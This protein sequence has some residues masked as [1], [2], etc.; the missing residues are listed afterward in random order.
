MESGLE[1]RELLTGAVATA[2]LTGWRVLPGVRSERPLALI[3]RGPASSPGCPEAAARLVSTGPYPLR[4]RFCGPGT[5][6]PVT[7]SLLGSARVFVQP[8][9]G[10]DLDAAWRSVRPM[11]SML[12]DWV[13]GGGRYLGLCMGGFLA[14]HDPGYGLLA[15]DSAEYVG[16]PGSTVRDNSDALVTVNW[17]ARSR[18]VYFQGGPT[19]HF[20]TS[21]RPTVLARYTNGAP[22][23]AVVSCGRG[24]VAVS[25][26]HPEAPVSWYRE[27]GLPIPTPLP[28]TLGWELVA[29]LQDR[30]ILSH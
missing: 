12:G 11:A 26:P 1:R 25:G 29:Q 22:A 3:Y 16:S 18:R 21:V 7:P 28:T 30:S 23:M 5:N 17:G 8:G 27:A 13:R 2:V 9:G 14:G 19:F 10:D 6:L 4:V 15:G 24:R 20:D